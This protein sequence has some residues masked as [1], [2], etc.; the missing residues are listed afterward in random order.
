MREKIIR[1]YGLIL[2]SWIEDLDQCITGMKYGTQVNM[3]KTE[4]TLSTN[5]C[6]QRRITH[7]MLMRNLKLRAFF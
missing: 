4:E 3:L 5:L 2:F 1:L 6:R 7:L